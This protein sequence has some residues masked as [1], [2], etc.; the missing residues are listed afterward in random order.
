VAAEFEWERA[1][2][3][4]ECLSSDRL[5]EMCEDL[6]GRGTKALLV[7]RNDRVVYEWYEPGR[8][9]GDGHYT[10]SLAK[11]LVGG[12][13]L[14]L[15]LQDGLISVDDPA[16]KYVPQWR[17]APRKGLITIRH[18]ATHSSGIEDAELSEEDRRC[19]LEEGR[20]LTDHHMELPG[21]KGE[22][23]RQDPN[24]FLSARDDAPV[25]FCPGSR[26]AYSNPGM[27]MLS[28]CV[29][30]A[31]R[32][33]EHEDIRTLLRERVMRPIGVPDDEWSVGY[34]KTF[35][36]DGLPL[37]PN[38]GGG[39]F[40]PRATARV[41]RL[42]LRKGNWQGRQLLDPEWVDRVTAYAG[43]PLPG[44]ADQPAP[45]S[46]L[47]W[48]VNH[49]GVWPSMPRDTVAGGGAGNQH[50]FVIPTLDMIVV[51]NGEQIGETFWGGVEEYLL[52]PLAE[53]VLPPCPP[54]PVIKRI[55]WAPPGE[56]V[57]RCH[58]KARDGSDNWPL[59]WA[60]DGDLYTA[61]GDGWGFDP[62]TE[63]KLS[64]G[65]AKVSGSPPDI[66]GENVRSNVEEGGMGRR[67]RK[68]SGILM[69]DGTLHLWA[70]NADHDGHHS[71]LAWSED[72]GEDWTWADWRFEEFGYC[73]FLNFGRNYDG[74]RDEFVYVYSHD[75]PSAYRAADRMIL[76]RVPKGRVR[77]REA[78][79]FFTGLDARGNPVW[80]GD[81][82]ERG[83]VFTHKGRCL[84]SGVTYNAGL[85]RYL[86]WQQLPNHPTEAQTRFSGGF[87][88]YDAPEPWGPWT[89]VYYTELWDVGPGETASFPTKWMS[90][91][92]RTVHLV[93]SGND[94]FA[95]RR[96]ELILR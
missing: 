11:A 45:A 51:R 29:T 53:A 21:W 85:G 83:A 68:G 64:M 70:R 47:G 30:A 36:T 46:G 96:A 41:G 54:S 69:V 18:L 55:E 1:T 50:L 61:W 94:T 19:A 71:Q 42:M 35:G 76:M 25:I 93:F 27:A 81:L 63:S 87:A 28:Y 12:M 49:D 34:E 3:E 90:E 10:A 78:Y 2:P 4:D 58:M 67:G 89:A 32:G 84:R 5:D 31:L 77:E 13:S 24:P 7:V 15:A 82:E 20:T 39:G 52:R 75:N 37:V 6:A 8:A 56:I 66:E 91:D 40:S 62:P 14:T 23:W 88:V 16:Y 73:T 48:Y 86:W 9:P 79:E 92:G 44:R 43:T 17:N 80:S 95:V 38:W 72:H 33:T 22:F 60:D 59:T 26:Y 74:A 65:C 57:R